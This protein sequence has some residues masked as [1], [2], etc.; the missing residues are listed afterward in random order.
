M[1]NHILNFFFPPLCLHC[2]SVLIHSHNPLCELCVSQLELIEPEERCIYCFGSLDDSL[3]KICPEC[4]CRYPAYHHIAS[5]FDYEGPFA[6][7]IKHFKYHNK[8][9]LSEGIASYLLYQLVNLNWPIPDIIVPMPI[10]WPHWIERGYN[11][12]LLLAKEL[13]KLLNVPLLDPLKRKSTEYS[14][15]GKSK[16]QRLQLPTDCFSIDSKLSGNFKG[17][18]ILPVSYTHLT[19]P[20][21]A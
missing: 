19:L 2:R 17:K 20:T 11:Q 9:W 12:C 3:A 10:C 8:P 18:N 15:A 5:V 16:W 1:V 6:S 14:Q 13:A 21:K 4:Y 7:L